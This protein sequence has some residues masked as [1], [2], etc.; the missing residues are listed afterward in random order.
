MSS[1]PI[2]IYPGPIHMGPGYFNNQRPSWIKAYAR[3]VRKVGKAAAN[4]QYPQVK[5]WVSSQLS[6][7]KNARIN[8]NSNSTRT[9]SSSRSSRKTRRR[10]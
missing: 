3:A 2:N 7:G 9:A 6:L 5:N 1:A 10:R 4:R 8:Y